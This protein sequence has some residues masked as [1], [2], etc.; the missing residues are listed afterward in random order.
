MTDI[1][2]TGVNLEKLTI[3]K[4]KQWAKE[5]NLKVPTRLTKAK[6][7]SHLQEQ[8]LEKQNNPGSKEDINL[9]LLTKPQIKQ[10][11]KENN[12]KAPGNLNKQKL[13][14]YV[15]GKWLEKQNGLNNN[16][17]Q[18]ITLAN[19]EP[20]SQDQEIDWLEHLKE[21]GWAVAP[22]DNWCTTFE[23][24]FFKFLISC[25][26]D[27]NPEDPKTWIKQNLPDK[28]M[29]RG[30]IKHYMGHTEWQWK[31]REL[32]LPIF[33]RIWET[34]D[35]LCSFDGGCFLAPIKNKSVT[36]WIH[37]DMPKGLSGFC[38]VQG[39]VNFVENGE[40][41]GGLVLLEGSQDVFDEYMEKYPSSGLTWEKANITD[42][43]LSDKTMIK[44]CAPA[45]TIILFDSRIFHCNVP[46]TSDNYRMCTYVSMQP[47]EGA[48][49]AELKKRISLYKTGRMTGHWCY[50]PGFYEN[51]KDPQFKDQNVPPVIEIAELTDTLRRLIGY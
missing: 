38:C 26:K 9:S 40:N 21:H 50:G 28:I 41:D 47:R 30:V 49:E 8:L 5:N 35:L 24:D 18:T 4:I 51:A 23:D 25:C 44:I 22:L 29:S 31:I 7:I 36:G 6:L 12:I 2:E 27:F 20:R 48:S 15:Q 34:E 13:V 46:P 32:C 45:G 17:K 42:P 14:T 19:L 43:L 1:C 16:N 10:W 39:I 11:A 3:P 37:H 33:Q